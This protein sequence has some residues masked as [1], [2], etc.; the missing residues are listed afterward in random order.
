MGFLGNWTPLSFN[1]K[2]TKVMTM[3][4]LESIIALAKIFSLKS[5]TSS[6]DVM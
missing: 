4:F 5:R 2:S 6:E 3:K 1:S